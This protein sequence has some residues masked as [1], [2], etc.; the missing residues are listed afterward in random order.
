[1]PDGGEL[2]MSLESCN[3]SAR[4]AVRDSGPGIQPELLGSIDRTDCTTKSG[5][6]GV[7]LSVARSVVQAHGGQLDVRSAAG[8]VLTLPLDPSSL[9][10]S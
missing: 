9:A 7:G 5:G 1:M 2:S 6:T 4:I 8:E 10:P 3:G